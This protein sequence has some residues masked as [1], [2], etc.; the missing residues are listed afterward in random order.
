M[1]LL[2]I[3]AEAADVLWEQM[4]AEA[5]AMAA[6][7]EMLRPL[8]NAAVLAQRSLEQVPTFS[9][10]VVVFEHDDAAPAGERRRCWPQ[11][12]PQRSL[13]QVC[14]LSLATFSSITRPEEPVTRAPWPTPLSCRSAHP[15]KLAIVLDAGFYFWHPPVS[16]SP[17]WATSAAAPHERPQR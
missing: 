14:S 2:F 13:V 15:S 3:G 9:L 1:V 11:C 16:P 10:K 4:R 8:V 12:S 5:E 17:P 7:E 6:T